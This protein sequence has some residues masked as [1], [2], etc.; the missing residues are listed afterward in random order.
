M[1]KDDDVGKKETDLE[2]Q[3]AKEMQRLLNTEK[4]KRISL[5]PLSYF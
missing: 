5:L 1:K 2:E 3:G 4:F